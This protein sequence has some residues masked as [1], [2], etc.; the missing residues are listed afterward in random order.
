MIYKLECAH[1][2]TCLPDYWSGHHLPHV[3]IPVYNGMTLKEIK[4]Q[5]K[6]EL[7]Q[8]AV[9]GSNNDAF[10]LASDFVGPENEKDADQIFKAAIASVNRLKPATKGQ[11]KF[12]TDLEQTSEDDESIYAFFVFVNLND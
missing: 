9:A 11:K 3:Q 1:V 10:L 4:E 5:I 7:S 6:I 2:D 8:G 12:F